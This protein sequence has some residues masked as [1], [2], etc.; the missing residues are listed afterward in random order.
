MLF[1]RCALRQFSSFAAPS[2]C[3]RSPPRTELESTARQFVGQLGT[4]DTPETEAVRSGTLRE[5]RSPHSDA[6]TPSSHQ[7]THSAHTLSHT[8][9][10][11]NSVDGVRASGEPTH[12]LTRA[13]AREQPR[14]VCS[15]SDWTGVSARTCINYENEIYIDRLYDLPRR[16]EVKF[17]LIKLSR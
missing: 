1:I 4:A 14:P 17:M 6:H 10:R 7:P 9:G 5:V 3:T 11:T 16:N 13:G 12:T 2:L 8:A 15:V